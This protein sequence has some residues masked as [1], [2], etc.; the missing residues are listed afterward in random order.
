MIIAMSEENQAENVDVAMAPPL[1]MSCS[2]AAREL[3]PA[4]VQG[5]YTDTFVLNWKT[6]SFPLLRNSLPFHA[7]T[8]GNI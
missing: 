2:N 8:P 6:L 4:K 7:T 1:P 3:N 5:L